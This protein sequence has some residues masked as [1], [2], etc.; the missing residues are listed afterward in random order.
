MEI[1]KSSIVGSKKRAIFVHKEEK[2]VKDYFLSERKGKIFLSVCIKDDIKR[3]TKQLDKYICLKGKVP[4][5]LGCVERKNIILQL[6]R[7]T[8]TN[9]K[10][11]LVVWF[12]FK[13]KPTQNYPWQD[14]RRVA[15]ALPRHLFMHFRRLIR[16]Y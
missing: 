1:I 13:K 7:E 4:E 8:K 5:Y 9:Q 10:D 3:D 11:L 15:E 16:S 6:M 12:D 14:D 2:G